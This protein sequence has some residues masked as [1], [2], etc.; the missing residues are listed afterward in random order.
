MTNDMIKKPDMA[1]DEETKA[2]NDVDSVH[3]AQSVEDAAADDPPSRRWRNRWMW[4][5]ALLLAALLGGGV[6]GYVRYKAAADDV[7]VLR[8]AEADRSNAAQLANAY[9]L[10][11]LTYSFEDPDAFF[12]SVEDGASESLKDKYINANDLLRGVMLQAQVTSTGE[13]LATQ[14]TAQPGNVYQVV[15]S[16]SQ[17]TRNL[18]N[19]QPRVSIILL[20]ITVNKV[21]NTWQISDI[22]PKTG[23]Q[24]VTAEQSAAPK[25]G[26]GPIAPTPK[27]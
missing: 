15:V 12:R 20:A 6:F 24:E 10:K 9:A 14:A 1:N 18:Q 11:S 21:G 25:P 5:S 2:G 8:Q 27:P 4:V 23:S 3:G 7:A 16:A 19:P 22:G 17:T 13:V 26:A